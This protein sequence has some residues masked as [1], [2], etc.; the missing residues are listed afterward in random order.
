MS[1]QAGARRSVAVIGGGIAGISAA[2][3]LAERG[4]DVTLIEAESFLGGRAGAWEERLAG[5]ET[6]QMERGFHAFFRQYYNLRALLRRIDPSLGMLVPVP[7]YPL[8][9]PSGWV[10]SFAGL[11]TKTPLNIMSLVRRTPTMGWR[12]LMGVNVRSALSM[13]TFDMEVTYSKYDR[14]TARAYLDSLKFPPRA[15]QM[16]FDIF[17][18]SF[19]NPEDRM[20]AAELLMMF[21]FYFTGNPEGLVFDVVREPFGK[22]LWEPFAR[23]LEG[24]GVSIRTRTRAQ[25]IRRSDQGWAVELYE[26]APVSAD[27]VVLAT[28]VPALKALVAESVDLNVATLRASVESLDVTLP[29]AVWRMW[30]DR[31]ALPERLPFVGT[32]GLGILDNIS[33]F[34][35]FEGE[36]QRWAERT[37]GSVLEAHAYAIPPELDEQEAKADMRKAIYELYP[38]TRGARVLEERYFVRRD[39]PAFHIGS[40]SLR[41]GVTTPIDS[42]VLAGD[43]V[44]LPY[45][46]ALME[47]AA[48]SGMLAAN[49][50]LSRWGGGKEEIRTVSSTGLLG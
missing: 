6:F 37:G 24:K 2:T 5:G 48:T 33:L 10:E 16:L 36:S 8:L 22:A 25:R 19:F 15:R 29:F 50:L 49:H 41:P 3:V 45:P 34:E 30:L 21:H 1:A 13:L 11:P 27:A 38:E 7:D 17:S 47:R 4:V 26:G 12:D 35:R 23:Y 9:G 20:S 40:H 14:V 18:H 31:P 32:T 42:V 39:C 46:T 43:F 44:K 28:H